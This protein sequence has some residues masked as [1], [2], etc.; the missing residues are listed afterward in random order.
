MTIS[1][2]LFSCKYPY[3]SRFRSSGHV[4]VPPPFL[5]AVDFRSPFLPSFLFLAF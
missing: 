2:R 4:I 3:L 5:V 1:P